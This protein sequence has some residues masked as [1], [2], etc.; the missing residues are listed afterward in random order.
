MMRSTDMSCKEIKLYNLNITFF[1]PRC[2]FWH[3]FRAV[4]NFITFLVIWND[5]ITKLSKIKAKPSGYVYYITKKY[6]NII[7]TCIKMPKCYP[8]F[9][10]QCL[11]YCII[12]ISRIPITLHTWSLQCGDRMQ[13]HATSWGCESRQHSPVLHSY[14][15]GWCPSR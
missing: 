7:S 9:D 6:I 2:L 3:I 4:H 14:L 1:C 5:V 8:H 12:F 11:S 13:Y 10:Q 15:V